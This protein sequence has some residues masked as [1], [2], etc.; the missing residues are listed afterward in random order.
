[1][2]SNDN[3]KLLIYFESEEHL[4]RRLGAAVAS[5]WRELDPRLRRDLVARATR[6]LDDDADDDLGARIERFLTLHDHRGAA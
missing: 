6:V 3:E 1:M 5:C 4:V 2:M